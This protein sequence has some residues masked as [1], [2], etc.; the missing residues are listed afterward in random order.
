MAKKMS[1]IK[2]K[3]K[4]TRKVKRAKSGAKGKG[5][6]YHVKLVGAKGDYRNYRIQDVGR[7]GHSKRIAGQRDDGR[8]ETDAW[9]ISKQ[10]ARKKGRKLVAEDPRAQEI[11]DHFG[12]PPR[13]IEGDRFVGQPRG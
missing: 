10:D 9:L 3:T 11:L 6:Y 7:K 5:K 13:H 8:W 2:V 1:P 4:K 12:S